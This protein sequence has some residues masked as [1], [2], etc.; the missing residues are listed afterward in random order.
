MGEIAARKTF[1]LLDNPK[2]VKLGE[3]ITV[4]TYIINGES[5]R[6]LNK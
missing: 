4:D 1:Q 6:V 2:Q 5:T 3:S